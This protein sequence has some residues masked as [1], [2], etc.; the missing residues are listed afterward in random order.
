MTDDIIPLEEARR[1]EAEQS[2][3]ALELVDRLLDRGPS[4]F[5]QEGAVLSR[6]KG[7][8]RSPR[9]RREDHLAPQELHGRA[10]DG[11][12]V[13]SGACLLCFDG[14]SVGEHAA[15]QKEDER[16]QRH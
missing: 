11:P 1:R 4:G 12:L 7:H 15:H 2:G 8:F 3:G 14:K 9:S 16:A 10:D 6:K 5:S 13:V